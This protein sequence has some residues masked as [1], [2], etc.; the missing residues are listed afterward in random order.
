MENVSVSESSS[1]SENQEFFSLLNYFLLQPIK[2]GLYG[3]LA[4]FIVL[5]LAKG[6]L[7]FVGI[8]EKYDLNVDDAVFS[9]LG[10][11]I[12][13]IAKLVENIKDKET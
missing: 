5:A 12:V 3:F 7:Y 8:S 13:S 11:I 6:V 1:K 10:L 9:L 2:S 4:F